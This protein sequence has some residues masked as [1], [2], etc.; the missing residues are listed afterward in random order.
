MKKEV[1]KLGKDILDLANLEKAKKEIITLVNNPGPSTS[2]NKSNRRELEEVTDAVRN[3]KAEIEQ[4]A[5][6]LKRDIQVARVSGAKAAAKKESMKRAKASRDGALRRA[7]ERGQVS[8]APHIPP[9]V[10][11]V[12]INISNDTSTDKK[13]IDESRNTATKNVRQDPGDDV[14]RA[15]GGK[16]VNRVTKELLN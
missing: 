11:P 16:G 5:K 14:L 7:L 1:D 8:Q 12:N 15:G 9:A 2:K 10:S 4:E 6:K 3:Q 13:V